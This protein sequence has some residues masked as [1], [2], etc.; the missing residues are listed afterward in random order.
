MVDRTSFAHPRVLLHKRLRAPPRQGCDSG[1]TELRSRWGAIVLV[2]GA[3]AG[4]DP[5]SA[6]EAGSAAALDRALA[7]EEIRSGSAS[8]QLLP[9]LDRLA[10]AQFEDGA[11]AEATASRSRALKIAL[12][13]YGRDSPDAA[14]AMTAL[15]EV[16]ILRL[17]YFDAEP[18]LTAAVSV[19][20]TQLGHDNPALSAP[21]ADLARTALARGEFARAERL[22]SRAEALSAHDPNPSSQ[23]LRVLGATYAAEDRFDEG[24]AVLRRALARDRR[25]HGEASE[26]AARS[27]AQLA[28]LMMRAGRFAEALPLLE[29]ATA[30]DQARL[31][32]AHPLIADDFCD[33]G[34]LYA[35]LRRDVDASAILAYAIGL[36]E[37]GGGKDSA[38]LAYAELD[39]AGVLRTMGY[40]DAANTVFGD[41]KRILDK[42]DEEERSREGDA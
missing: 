34:L 31:G 4:A 41:A 37:Q 27:V 29:E 18:L 26:Q 9:L 25:E 1:V 14:R 24:E 35:G 19:L 40:N 13:A 6:A 15:A 5:V 23:P 11:L 36:I 28:N 20:T 7:A 39:L 33:I 17:H 38:R 2:V 32:A 3:L 42:A 8:P 21:L 12:A 22:A 30:I 10:G 16:D